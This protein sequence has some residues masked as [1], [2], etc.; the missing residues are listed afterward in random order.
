M[1]GLLS[2]DK[3]ASLLQAAREGTLDDEIAAGAAGNQPRVQALDFS[4]PTK[5]GLEVQ[6]RL[7][8]A[9]ETYCQTASARIA[10]E[11]GLPIK[12]ELIGLM[13]LSYSAAQAMVPKGPGA[14]LKVGD[15]GMQIQLA[16]ELPLVLLGIQRLMGGSTDVPEDRHLTEIDLVLSERVFQALVGPLSACWEEIAAVELTLDRIDAE[17]NHSAALAPV[18]EPTLVISMEARVEQ[19]SFTIL[20]LIPYRSI[21]PISSRLWQAVDMHAVGNTG[22]S[23]GEAVG[24]ALFEVR[25]EVGSLELTVAE[26]MSL[27]VGQRVV[28]GSERP[29]TATLFVGDVAVGAARPGR[30]GQHRAVQVLSK[31]AGS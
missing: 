28:L 8:R 18:S 12:L 22:R 23:L 7:R 25:A 16:A 3:I 9:H 30:H 31:V 24:E 1:N 21:E 10:L 29:G 11:I 13:Q 15:L 19:H 17:P 14:T 20:L 4:R 27:E 26:L 6:R 5:F 2:E